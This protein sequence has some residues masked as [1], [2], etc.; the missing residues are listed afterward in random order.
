MYAERFSE[1]V[2]EEVEKYLEMEAK[3]NLLL[4]LVRCLILKSPAGGKELTLKELLE[5]IAGH[6]LVM[7]L[8]ISPFVLLSILI[9]D[10]KGSLRVLCAHNVW[11]HGTCVNDSMI[12]WSNF[13]MVLAVTFNAIFFLNATMEY[14]TRY[15]LDMLES[16]G[17]APKFNLYL[18]H[19]RSSKLY[20]LS[21]SC[22]QCL[23]LFIFCAYFILV[24][25]FILLGTLLRPST[26]GPVLLSISG[27]AI[28]GQQ[29]TVK[30]NEIV[31]KAKQF[32]MDMLKQAESYMK[33]GEAV[34]KGLGTDLLSKI[35]GG[36][37]VSDL[38]EKMPNVED[39]ME[40]GKE[41]MTQDSLGPWTHFGRQVFD[42]MGNLEDLQRLLQGAVQGVA[43]ANAARRSMPKSFKSF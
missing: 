17:T 13:L 26:L 11:V 40:K 2:A 14:S 42:K 43:A 7:Q 27:A 35:P 22:I 4:T 32:A 31:E 24:F 38:L 30:F 39:L 23:T 20:S 41:H 29:I 5:M 19:I 36:E 34:V 16:T 37:K 18:W 21:V 15:A 1:D 33:E 10:N 28:V 8:L 9:V 3:S 6:F 12:G 25:L